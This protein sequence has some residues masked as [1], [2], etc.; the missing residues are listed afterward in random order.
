MAYLSAA[1]ALVGALCLFDLVLSLGVIRRLREQTHLINQLAASTTGTTAPVGATVEEFAATTTSGRVVSRASTEERT[2]V[3]FV[4]PSCAPCQ[5][6]L[7]A[8]EGYARGFAGAVVSVVVGEPDEASEYARRLGQLGE[9]VVEPSGGPMATAFGVG[10]LP[11]LCVVDARG[12]VVASSATV[13][14]LPTPV[15][16]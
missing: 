4:S 15:P 12:R 8:F 11:A 3:G 13:E 16:A 14:T 5:E 1:V 2:L 9:V 10:G 6:L 7:P